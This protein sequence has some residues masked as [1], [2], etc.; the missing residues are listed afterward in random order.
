MQYQ[1]LEGHKRVIWQILTQIYIL[2][3]W[4][5][6]IHFLFTVYAYPNPSTR[7]FAIHTQGKLTSY[8]YS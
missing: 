2:Y 4:Y 8:L 7:H 3:L 1:V 6:K 5:P